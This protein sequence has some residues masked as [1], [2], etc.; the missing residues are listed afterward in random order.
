M[1]TATVER[2]QEV[3]GRGPV[4]PAAII[5]NADEK[6]RDDVA[7]N[8][9]NYPADYRDTR[10]GTRRVAKNQSRRSAEISLSGLGIL[11]VFCAEEIG[12][13]RE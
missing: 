1:V 13:I 9:R 12:I 8:C 10:H 4:E 3:V 2:G 11:C 6:V 7:R 5:A